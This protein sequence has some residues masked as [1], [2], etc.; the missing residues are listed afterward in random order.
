MHSQPQLPA[1]QYD[2]SH[3]DSVI[4]KEQ[5]SDYKLITQLKILLF[6]I[7]LYLW[8]THSKPHQH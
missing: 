7:P 6:N 2:D 8:L 1:S 5:S 4:V 3:S